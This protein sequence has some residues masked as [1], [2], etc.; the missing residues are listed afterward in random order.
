MLVFASTGT[1]G[2]PLGLE[3]SVTAGIISAKNRRLQV[4]KRL[5]EEIFQTD[6]AINPGNSGG[7]L[8][9]LNGE[10]IGLNAFIIQSSQCLGFAIGI[11]ALKSQL[12]QYAFK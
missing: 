2:S 1:S 3:N 10:V 7:P 5:Y 9:N 11:D 8:I 4:A 6:A 12:E